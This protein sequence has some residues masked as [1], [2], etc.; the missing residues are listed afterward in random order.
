MDNFN[1]NLEFRNTIMYTNKAQEWN[2]WN[3]DKKKIN[4]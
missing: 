2:E 1:E 3:R 4:K